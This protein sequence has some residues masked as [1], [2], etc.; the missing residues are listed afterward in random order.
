MDVSGTRSIAPQRAP[1]PDRHR[2]EP[3]GTPWSV[4]SI[5]A[6][7]TTPGARAF[8]HRVA[9]TLAAAGRAVP[10]HREDSWDNS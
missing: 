5:G 7:A 6:A 3:N 1:A 9:T 8:L 2:R 4:D 10:F